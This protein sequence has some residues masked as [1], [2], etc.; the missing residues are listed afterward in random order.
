MLFRGGLEKA[1]LIGEV[2]IEAQIGESCEVYPNFFDSLEQAHTNALV[3]IIEDLSCVVGLITDEKAHKRPHIVKQVLLGLG[4]SFDG[5][6]QHL[7]RDR[8]KI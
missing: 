6:I 7:A 5:L 4:E 2:V 3:G 8:P 1:D